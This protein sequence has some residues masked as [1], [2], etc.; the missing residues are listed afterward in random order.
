[1]KPPPWEPPGETAG[2]ALVSELAALQAAVDRALDRVPG[3]SLDPCDLCVLDATSTAVGCGCECTVPRVVEKR[4]SCM[5]TCPMFEYAGTIPHIDSDD[6]EEA[7]PEDDRRMSA[8][9]V[10]TGMFL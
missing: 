7:E 8:G 6:E 2:E 1:M 3:E 9:P 4:D 10:S 5:Q